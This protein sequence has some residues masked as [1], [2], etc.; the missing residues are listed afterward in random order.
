MI[1]DT[2]ANLYQYIGISEAFDCAIDYLLHADFGTMDPAKYPVDGD[3]V[4]TLVQTP[5]TRLKADARWESHQ[6]YIDIQY[7]IEGEEII[8]FQKTDSMTVSVPYSAEKDIV[9]YDDNGKGSFTRLFPGAFV[10]YFPSEAHMPLISP[11]TPQRIKKAVI[12][13]KA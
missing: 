10:I 1:Y 3:R 8:G 6:N 4:F 13:V 11:S 5:D 2:K 7:L 12:K 9:F